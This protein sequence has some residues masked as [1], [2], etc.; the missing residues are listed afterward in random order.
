MLH[1]VLQS[2]ESCKINCTREIGRGVQCGEEQHL[3]RTGE[4][5]F[6]SE[7]R[8][9]VLQI[10]ESPM[11]PP[12]NGRGKNMNTYK[13]AFW[14]LFAMT[15]LVC[16]DRASNAQEE[17]QAAVD[18]LRSNAIPIQTVEAGHG[19]ADLQKLDRVVGN[20]RIVELGEATHGTR[21]FFQLKHR[22]VEY[23]ATKKGFTIFSIEANM[24]EAYRLND[25]VLRGEGD[26]KQLIKGMYFWT[27]D[28]QEV[29][30]MVLWMREFNRSGRG[31]IEF[32]GFDM[33][34]PTVSMD[35]VRRFVA[36]HDPAYLAATLDPLYTQIQQASNHA[37]SFGVATASF[38][39]KPAAA[40]KHVSLSGFLRTEDVRDGW[41]GL[42]LRAD[43]AEKM[44]VAFK[45]MDD[46]GVTGTTPWTRYEISID[47]PANAERIV[48]GALNTGSGTAWVD[49]LKITIDGVPFTDDSSFDLG[50]EAPTP[51]GFYTGGAGYEVA[52]DSTL[53][54]EGKQSLRMKRVAKTPTRLFPPIGEA[55][56]QKSAA[57]T[58]YLASN[59]DSYING[60]VPARDIDWIIQNARLVQQYAELEAGKK[61]RDESMA[62]NVKWIADQNPGA[63][64]VLWAHN[65]HVSYGAWGNN[66]AMGS[67]LGKMFG[68]EL[69]SF[70]FAFNEGGFRAFEQ[71]KGLH[72]FSV[73]PATEKD[74]TLDATLARTGIP[75]FA[76]DLRQ[77]PE[78]GPVAKW[79][80]GTHP[81]RSIGAVYSEDTAHLYWT[82]NRIKDEFDVLLFVEKTTA[83]RGN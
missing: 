3:V 17:D 13:R 12:Y 52:I 83:A 8:E 15:V 80:D 68:S 82:T 2:T 48:F 31:H 21:E 57:V 71:G 69:I 9:S 74:G 34:T 46:H 56:L 54:N 5:M 59:R 22:M 32:T 63:K 72:E 79:F 50:F 66:L 81:S 45:N 67:Y 44:P 43:G 47:V 42:W 1:A 64:I 40:G 76:I 62:D 19:F 23:L 29:L 70:G 27:W 39:A 61:T 65:A 41:A 7:Q 60:G 58:K 55:Q 10:T 16:A 75:V 78:K 20:A 77:L 36:H 53:A 11:T 33:Q 38:A 49:S 18:W 25:Y 35:I 26:P 24:P 28:T 30:D 6:I 51:R 37:N 73:G 4:G 14:L